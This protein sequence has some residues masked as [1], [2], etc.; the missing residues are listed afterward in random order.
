MAALVVILV[1]ALVVVAGVAAWMY[2]RNR[3]TERL[4]EQF[5]PE[6]E[7]AVQESGDRGRAEQELAA[8][9]QRVESL[10]IRPLPQGDRTRFADAWRATQARFVDDPPGAIAEADTLIGEVMQARGYPIGDFDA[11][12]AD[13]SV[14][15]AEVVSHYRAAHRIAAASR[16]GEATTEQL[17]QAMVHYRT[18]FADLLEMQP[19]SLAP[20]STQRTR[21]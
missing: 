18:L 21:S 17:R 19:D 14:D 4:R 20:S 16:K 1:I 8:R 3:R 10:Q 7:H 13:L 6:Y 5:G 2:V 9:Q 15:H 12:A 11:R